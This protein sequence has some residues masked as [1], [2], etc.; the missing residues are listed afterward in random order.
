VLWTSTRG[1]RVRIPVAVEFSDWSAPQYIAPGSRGPTVTTSF[2]VHADLP[3]RVAVR[4]GGLLVPQ[5]LP[6]IVQQAQ[7]SNF[8]PS[9]AVQV[10]IADGNT[11]AAFAIFAAD[12]S[13]PA[14]DIEMY[15]YYGSD[16]FVGASRVVGA[17][18][19]LEAVHGLPWGEYTIYLY[20][21]NVPRGRATTYVHVWQSGAPPG[22]GSLAVAPATLAFGGAPAAPSAG[23]DARHT[24]T[25]TLSGLQV[26]GSPVPNRCARASAAL[27]SVWLAGCA[28]CAAV[29][30]PCLLHAP[31]PPPQHSTAPW[32]PCAG[33]LTDRAARTRATPTLH[34][35][36]SA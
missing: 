29:E 18:Q 3:A 26:G 11:Y 14:A 34:A 35:G 31:H 7:S 24:V 2:D 32:L 22:P 1:H 13:D 27:G 6:L 17:T 33:L 10:S 4:P 12:C 23:A 8:D 9:E 28:G 16:I 25:A 21:A 30:L 5:A 36:T 20:G 19:L 15:I